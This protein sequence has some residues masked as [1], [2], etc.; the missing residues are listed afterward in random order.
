[1]TVACFY[2]LPRG[3][4]WLGCLDLPAMGAV[5]IKELAANSGSSWM[6]QALNI[7]FVKQLLIWCLYGCIAKVVE[8]TKLGLGLGLGL[9]Y[10][11]Q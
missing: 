3:G 11:M 2:L 5:S 9:E 4:S 6:F 7:R 8:T 10:R 1:V